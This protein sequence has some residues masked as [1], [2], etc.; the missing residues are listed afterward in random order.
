M[1]K[2]KITCINCHL[3][4]EAN[5]TKCPYCGK[6]ISETERNTEAKPY[7]EAEEKGKK[8]LQKHTIF[9]LIALGL[10]GLIALG[11]LLPVESTFNLSG[12][13]YLS[14]STQFQLGTTSVVVGTNASLIIFIFTIITLLNSA[15][16]FWSLKKKSAEVTLFSYFT[17]F[18]C[19]VITVL[20]FL[21]TVLMSNNSSGNAATQFAPGI[22]F[23]VT[24]AFAVAATVFNI[25]AVIRYKKFLYGGP[26]ESLELKK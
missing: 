3:P 1:K 7:F 11:L 26:K 5:V 12:Y 2:E 23:F 21:G 13:Y 10:E 24:S 22:G 15:A 14:H 25:L 19:V 4:L 17:A 16:I 20:S 8:R 18:Y 9:Y 6:E